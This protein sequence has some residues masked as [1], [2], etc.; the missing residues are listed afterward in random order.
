MYSFQMTAILVLFLV[1][2]CPYILK[3]FILHV[4][5]YLFFTL[6]HKRNYVVLT[7]YLKLMY[8]VL[9]YFLKIHV[10]FT[11]KAFKLRVL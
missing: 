4:L 8:Y 3:D 2:S 7:Y 6:I 5:M 9:M 1:L 11:S 10:L